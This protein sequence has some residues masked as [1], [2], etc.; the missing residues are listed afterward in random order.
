MQKSTKS[1]KPTIDDFVLFCDQSHIS[2]TSGMDKPY[3]IHEIDDSVKEQGYK[4][5]LVIEACEDEKKVLCSA[6]FESLLSESHPF[7]TKTIEKE[8]LQYKPKL[9]I[10][11]TLAHSFA[12][13]NRKE[14]KNIVSDVIN[15]VWN[16]N[17]SCYD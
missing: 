1:D 17:D 4:R 16:H 2:F 12:K 9:E 15:K 3:R 10:I 11:Q 8:S 6:Y 13:E 5:G 7:I 14:V